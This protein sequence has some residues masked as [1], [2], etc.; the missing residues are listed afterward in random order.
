M[1]L[2]SWL[3]LMFI[4]FSCNTITVPK[5]VLPEKKMRAVLWDMMR[6]DEWV[7]YERNRD[8]AVNQVTRSKELYQ[9]VFQI[10]GITAAQ[11]KKSFQ[12]YQ[13]HPDLLKPLLDS[14]Q[15]RGTYIPAAAIQ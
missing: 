6:A 3:L 10:N 15:K 5:D 7:N 13:N 2:N 14:L 8:T 1:K 11:F 9:Q 4:L 12:F